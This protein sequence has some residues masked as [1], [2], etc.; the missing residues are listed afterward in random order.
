MACSS[1]KAFNFKGIYFALEIQ[2]QLNELRDRLLDLKVLKTGDLG[3]NQNWAGISAN[4]STVFNLVGLPYILVKG[5]SEIIRDNF[6]HMEEINL[7]LI[8]ESNKY[9]EELNKV[10]DGSGNK[11]FQ[12]F[13]LFRRFYYSVMTELREALI[14][15]SQK[16]VE[17][18]KKTG[19]SFSFE[20][21][22]DNI[23]VLSNAKENDYTKMGLRIPDED[24]TK[25]VQIDGRDMIRTANN[26]AAAVANPSSVNCPVVVNIPYEKVEDLGNRIYPIVSTYEGKPIKTAGWISAKELINMLKND[27]DAVVSNNIVDLEPFYER[28]HT[29]HQQCLQPAAYVI[30][31]KNKAYELIAC[32]GRGVW[33]ASV[34]KA[35]TGADASSLTLVTARGLA[36]RSN[37][38]KTKSV[39]RKAA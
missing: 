10:Y 17:R 28:A 12:Y 13:N 31:G 26:S 7:A 4:Y 18:A 5:I 27:Y 38:D 19:A 6:Y 2:K 1:A 23:V 30:V 11:G 33:P 32:A 21:S 9:Y 22:L 16:D 25:F 39:V 8:P 20:T 29:I 15:A 34:V 36:G 14:K 24:G 3:E 35:T 37:S